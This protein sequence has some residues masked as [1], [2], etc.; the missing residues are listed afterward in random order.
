[1][2][3][4]LAEAL[5]EIQNKSYRQ[6]EMETAWKW[7]SRSAAAYQLV[8]NSNEKK[9]ILETFSVAEDFYHEAVEH[10][11]LV[12]EDASKLV[13]EVQEAILPYMEKAVKHMDSIILSKNGSK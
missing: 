13:K 2:S 5:E 12:E 3:L 8:S 6:I 10:A 1:M 4:N 7:A 11:A 9:H